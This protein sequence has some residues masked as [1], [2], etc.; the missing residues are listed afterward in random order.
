MPLLGSWLGSWRHEGAG[1][2]SGHE[3]FLPS[4]VSRPRGGNVQLFTAR[5]PRASRTAVT[6]AL[7]VYGLGLGLGGA[8]SARSIGGLCNGRPAS[9]TWLDASGQSGPT[10]IDG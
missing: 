9:H 6:T 2:R 3:P 1:E 4:S 5:G 8:G 10:L 7:V